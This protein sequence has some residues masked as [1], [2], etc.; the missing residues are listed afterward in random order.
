MNKKFLEK[1]LEAHRLCSD[2]PTPMEIVAFFKD[3]TGALYMDYAKQSFY[4]TEQIQ[5][6]LNDLEKTFAGLLVRNPDNDFTKVN[7][8]AAHFFQELPTIYDL[9]EKDIT[10][11]FEGDP[12]AKSRR[13]VIRSYPG[14]YATM[15][16]R[17]ANLMQKQNVKDIPRIL[18]EYAHSKTGIDINP[19]AEIGAYFCIDHGTGVVIGETAVIGE[20]CKIYQ[21][22]TLGALSVDKSD[23]NKKRHPT[24]EDGVIIYA[25]AT[26][27]GGNTIIG[28][29]SI[30]GGNVWITKSVPANTKLYYRANLQDGKGSAVDTYVIKETRS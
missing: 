26:I 3:L 22:V 19:G 10:A 21:G 7:E 12:A 13:E 27:L 2:C 28:E 1:L 30:I 14:F 18:T 5:A 9:L 23:A 25:N 4:S 16:Y 17:I 8:M 6:Y 11:I 29:N 20:H 24:L 15:V